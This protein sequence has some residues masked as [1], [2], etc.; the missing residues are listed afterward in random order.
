MAKD[1]VVLGNLI[2]DDVVL[3]DGSTRMGQ[4]GGAVLYAAL[5]ASLW[6]L[7]VGVVSL[8][9]S[10]YPE[11]ALAGM[12][13]SGIDLA[14]LHPLGRPGVRLWALYEERMRQLVHRRE[15]PRHSDVSP[16]VEH[17]PEAW[18]SARAFHV[19]PMPF[20]TQR[21]LVAALARLE[22][23]R[24]S[25]DPHQPIDQDSWAAWRDVL[26]D[27]D[28]LFVGLDELRL[29]PEDPESLRRLAGGRL[30]SVLFKRSTE[31]GTWYDAA[32]DKTAQWPSRAA[33]VVDPTGAGDAFAAG[34]L[35]GLLR[36]EPIERAI[37]RGVVGA[38]FAISGFG[39]DGLLAA[40]PAAAEAR[41]REWFPA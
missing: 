41:L 13:A 38:S 28:L 12:S 33:G 10:D 11:Q 36:G 4:P 3:S 34:T 20:E 27:V 19:S 25:L 17:I 29:A 1:L 8:V 21:T 30:R 26:A 23:A 2:V 22:G 39:P 16:R 31:G 37:R 15:R 40:K 14:G 6:G 5:G 18:R 35:A 9:G 7:D 32:V 24:L